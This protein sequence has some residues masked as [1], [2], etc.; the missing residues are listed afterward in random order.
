MH[1]TP[2]YVKKMTNIHSCYQV[3]SVG[4]VR[5]IIMHSLCSRTPMGLHIRIALPL[6]KLVTYVWKWYLTHDGLMSCLSRMEPTYSALSLPIIDVIKR[7]K[8]GE[9]CTVG[10]L[11]L[12]F[13]L[14]NYLKHFHG[15]I[16][17]SGVPATIAK[18]PPKIALPRSKATKN[19]STE[20]QG[21][22]R[23]TGVEVLRR[24]SG[25]PALRR[26]GWRALRAQYCRNACDIIL[27]E[28]GYWSPFGTNR[29][30]YILHTF[31]QKKVYE[32]AII[33]SLMFTAYSC[34]WFM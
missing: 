25:G 17:K 23:S 32:T 31:Y 27:H 33:P 6:M 22:G 7:I 30:L 4:K 13:L 28:A 24:P 26:G 15:I 21:F 12:I 14:R 29:S 1:D 19:P 18:L 8:T 11:S 9:G 34:F 2:V 16:N 20:D 3:Y 10:I 5:I